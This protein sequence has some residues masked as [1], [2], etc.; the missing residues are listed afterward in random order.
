MKGKFGFIPLGDL[1]L[2]NS[3]NRNS[4][5]QDI[6]ALHKM[7]KQ[8]ETYN[9]MAAQFQVISQLHPDKWQ[10]YLQDY[11]DEQL[12]ALLRYGFPLDFSAQSPLHHEITNHSSTVLYKDDVKAYL[13]E[14]KEFQAIF[15]PFKY[16][17]FDNMHFSPFLTRKKPGAAH[18]RVIVGL[19]YPF[20][21]A[22]NTGIDPEAYLGSPF[23]LTLP[24][25]DTI[26]HKVKE[27][28]KGSL[29]YKIDL[30]RIFRHVKLDPKDYNLLDYILKGLISIL[31]CLLGSNMA[32]PSFRE[33]AMP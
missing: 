21:S 13:N 16:P 22:V 3:D 26:T 17:P 24:T 18:R 23:L 29:L 14:E 33:S 6:I 12:C 1:L 20:C 7:V 30:S 11:W 19:S 10:K 25:I 9:F 31:A 2:L 5:M 28:G 32:W 27:N 8:S 4:P 15:G